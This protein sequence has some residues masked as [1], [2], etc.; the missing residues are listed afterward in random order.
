MINNALEWGYSYSRWQ[1]V[2]N[3]ILFKDTTNVRL[4]RTR[5]IHIYEADYNLALGVKWRAAMH[6]AEDLQQLNDGQCGSRPSRTAIEPV[7]IE[8]L[9]YEISRATRKPVIFTNYDATAC[10]DRIVPN[11]GML[12]SK[13]FGVPPSVTKFNAETL[14]LAEYH[15]RTELGLSSTGYRHSLTDTIYETG[16]GSANSPSI[17]CFLSSVMFDGYDSQA[18]PATYFDPDRQTRVQLGMIGFVDDCNGQTN[19]FDSGG[20]STTMLHLVSQ[21]QQ[22][23]QLWTDLLGASGGALE[24]SKCSCHILQW[25]FSLSGAPVLVPLFS[26]QDASITV[27]DS[28]TNVSQ[29]MEI[30]PVYTAHKTLGHYKAPIGNQKE[31]YR[32]LKEK[33]DMST[34]FLWKC[35]LTRLEAWTYYYACYLPSVGYPLSCSSLTRK[36]LDS[37]QQK[38]MSIII[39]RCGFN[40]HTKKAILYG[41]L[42]LGGASFCPLYM[43]Q[44]IGQTTL[45]LRHWRKNSV[46]GKLL[47]I[48][49]RWFQ[50]Q[51]GVSYP[52]L[53]YVSSPLP[54]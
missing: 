7:L 20:S 37:I 39:R 47:Q 4:D 21:T 24:L 10:Y 12:V 54:Q 16:Q 2:A 32:Q 31:Q 52:I 15:V 50:V 22:N 29:S 11:V 19:Q 30:L 8:E 41:P 46:A 3:T 42:E 18:S 44:G 14:R 45:F 48:A 43:Q 33:S 28:H 17:W 23:A 35:P 38:A 1:T 34:S 6:Q 53:Q 27:W 40:C 13:K 25:K 5:V 26:P 49:L 51:T 36:Q 9:Q